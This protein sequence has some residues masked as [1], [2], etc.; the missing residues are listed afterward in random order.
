MKYRKY[1]LACIIATIWFV[2][3]SSQSVFSTPQMFILA[4]EGGKE[5]GGHEF[6]TDGS[7]DYFNVWVFLYPDA[8]GIIEG[9]FRLEW[10][11][12]L[13]KVG[14]EQSEIL[15]SSIGDL[16][17]G[18]EFTTGSCQTEPFWAYRITLMNISTESRF[19]TIEPHSETGELSVSTCSD[20]SNPTTPMDLGL[21]F[22]Q[23]AFMCCGV[24]FIGPVY[25]VDDNAVRLVFYQNPNRLCDED[26]LYY[27]VFEKGTNA[28]DTIFVISEAYDTFGFYSCYCD[29]L[30]GILTLNEPLDTAKTYTLCVSGFGT[31][32]QNLGGCRYTTIRPLVTV[33]TAVACFSAFTSEGGICVEWTMNEPCEST[34]FRIT[35]SDNG[36]ESIPLD[37]VAVRQNGMNFS[38]VDNVVTPEQLYRYQVYLK[39][40]GTDRLLFETEKVESPRP[41]FNIVNYPNPF[42]PGTEISYFNAVEGP[43]SLEIFDTSGRLVRRLVKKTQ[44]AGEHRVFWDGKNDS[45]SGQSSGIYFCKLKSGK[46]VSSR[47][48]VLLR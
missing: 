14:V 10:P 25:Q 43:V 11:F 28:L 44:A 48:L 45:G 46:N 30:V 16:S 15:T 17:Y 2:T 41:P 47:K 12:N 7:L 34:D 20:P 3:I 32:C 38:F 22:N 13:I 21:A 36:S 19:I 39:D 29:S 4:G 33:G 27:R 9:S 6:W 37:N 23:S 40:D 24:P 31:E 18:I 5:C 8:E 1:I 26:H 42:N 35:R